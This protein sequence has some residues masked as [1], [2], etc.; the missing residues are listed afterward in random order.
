MLINERKNNPLCKLTSIGPFSV[1]QRNKGK[2]ESGP[3][4]VER[5]AVYDLQFQRRRTFARF[6]CYFRTQPHQT[7]QI[8]KIIH[9]LHLEVIF[10]DEDNHLGKY[11]LIFVFLLS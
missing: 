1:D 9:I 8:V 5:F 7:L 6:W 4:S 10:D 11:D 3:S 2:E